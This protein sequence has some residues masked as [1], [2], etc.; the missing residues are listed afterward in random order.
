MIKIFNQSLITQLEKIKDLDL[1]KINISIEKMTYIKYI[2]NIFNLLSELIDNLSRYQVGL[3]WYKNLKIDKNCI[4]QYHDIISSIQNYCKNVDEYRKT[5]NSLGI[6]N[7]NYE[8][9]NIYDLCL[10]RNFLLETVYTD[11]MLLLP[12]RQITPYGGSRK[13]RRNKKQSR[14]LKYN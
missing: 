9:K 14:K 7:Y 3:L 12:P 4:D 8:V 2:K 11:T 5:I 10:L 1:K 13:R 6:Y